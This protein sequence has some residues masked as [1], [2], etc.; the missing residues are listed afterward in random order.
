M[1]N[2]DP[3]ESNKKASHEALKM[4]IFGPWNELTPRIL[5]LIFS[6]D[7]AK[8]ASLKLEKYSLCL[9]R[10]MPSRGFSLMFTPG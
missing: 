7:P 4:K 1:F 5:K 10:K 3:K 9:F 8:P 2:P 6:P